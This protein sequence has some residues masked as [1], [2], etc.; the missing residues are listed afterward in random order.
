[1]TVIS[2]ILLKL[3]IA[4]NFSDRLINEEDRQWFNKAVLEQLHGALGL[5]SWTLT[6]FADCL[7][8]DFLTRANK[9][10]QELKVC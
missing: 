9:E 1:M 5:S 2:F 4:I 7:Y 10:Y 3:I 6:D 8:A